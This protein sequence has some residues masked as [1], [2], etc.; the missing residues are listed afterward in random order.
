MRNLQRVIW[1]II[2]EGRLSISDM[3]VNRRELLGAADAQRLGA[4]GSIVA[5]STGRSDPSARSKR[6]EPPFHSTT[7]KPL[8]NIKPL[9]SRHL[10]EYLFRGRDIPEKTAT[11]CHNSPRF[12]FQQTPRQPSFPRLETTYHACGE[13]MPEGSYLRTQLWFLQIESQ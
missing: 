7:G 8:A 13:P 6:F 9:N 1:N 3:T 12:R 11:P 10:R 5:C 2:S 4:D